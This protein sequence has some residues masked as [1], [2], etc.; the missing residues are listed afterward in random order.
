MLKDE[1]YDWKEGE[2][3]ARIYVTYLLVLRNA[4]GVFV[5]W[6]G[7]V[8]VFLSRVVEFDCFALLPFVFR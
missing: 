8:C 4:G 5:W 2:S 3:L 7:G 1:D 6:F